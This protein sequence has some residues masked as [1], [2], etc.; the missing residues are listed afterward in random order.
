[1]VLFV[2]FFFIIIGVILAIVRVVGEM[3]FLI[4]IV[5]YFNFW[6]WGLKEFIVILVVLVYNFVL[7]F[8]KF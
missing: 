4:F 1:M 7:V 3:V 8:Y 6:F 2:V 5:L